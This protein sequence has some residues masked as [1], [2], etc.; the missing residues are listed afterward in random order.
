MFL[1]GSRNLLISVL[2]TEEL[3]VRLSSVEAVLSG[4]GDRSDELSLLATQLTGRGHHCLRESGK[5]ERYTR[6]CSHEAEHPRDEAV[7]VR[8]SELSQ[9]LPRGKLHP[10]L[11][12]HI[13]TVPVERRRCHHLETTASAV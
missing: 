3:C 5:L 7:M 12:R 11:I 1:D 8:D 10:R 4:R 9:Q 6:M 13:R 2:R